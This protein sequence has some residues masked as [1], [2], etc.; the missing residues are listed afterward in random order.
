MIR[1]CKRLGSLIARRRLLTSCVS[2][3][4][5]ILA[6][7]TSVAAEIIRAI[8]R[9]DTLRARPVRLDGLVALRRRHQPSPI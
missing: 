6:S 8:L 9:R 1:R 5:K 4:A 3:A 2:N 7:T